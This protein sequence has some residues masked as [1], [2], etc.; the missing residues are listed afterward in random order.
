[1]G[2]GKGKNS[3]SGRTAVPPYTKRRGDKREKEERRFFVK[4]REKLRG[5]GI[6]M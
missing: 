5:E 3:F 2:T 4:Q 1:M 6:E